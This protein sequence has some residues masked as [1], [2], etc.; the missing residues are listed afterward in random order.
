MKDKTTT[1]GIIEFHMKIPLASFS[2][3]NI[4][5]WTP[6]LITLLCSLACAGNDDEGLVAEKRF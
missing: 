4:Y 2:Y 3:I 1:F 5:I 6:T